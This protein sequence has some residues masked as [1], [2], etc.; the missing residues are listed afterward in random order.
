MT[1][2]LGEGSYGSVSV[3][4]GKAIKKFT[5][6]P[7]LVQEYIALTYLRDCKYVVQCVGVDFSQLEL[8]MEL[9]DCSL[10]RWLDSNKDRG[11]DYKNNI[12]KIIRDI[13]IGLVELHDR[14]LAHGDI[15]PG[16]ILVKKEPI[17]AVL[18][19]CGFVSVAK[20]AKV[21][22][23][24]PAY[25]DPD[26]E[27]HPSHDM[28]SL[29]ICLLELIGNFR[30]PHPLPNYTQLKAIIKHKILDKQYQN[31]LYTLLHED[32]SKRPSSRDVLYLLYEESP[33]KPK[34]FYAD[35]DDTES[36][37]PKDRR[38][39][40]RRLMKTTA[41]YY[42]INRCKKGYGA[43]LDHLQTHNIKPSLYPL[44][45]NTTL[46]I[47]SSIFGKS[48]YRP[49]HVLKSTNNRYD[50]HYFYKVLTDL[51]NDERFVGLLLSI[52]TVNDR[53]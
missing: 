20:Y 2:F 36:K 13:L 11:V 16:N 48:G 12:K 14:D 46:M 7:H 26:I 5:K 25:R 44:Y 22:R 41:H 8:H 27:H 37:I 10:R 31:L 24:A 6:L 39:A 32:K 1:T 28:Y 43:L 34:K 4:N 42:K 38:Q 45:T 47:L 35:S 9:Y 33:D 53:R 29:G 19:D 23:T 50:N 18:G 51:L 3:R 15:K 21:E 49:R 52:Q 30:L 40:I 17:S